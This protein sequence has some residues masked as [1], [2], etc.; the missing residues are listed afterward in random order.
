MAVKEQLLS[1]G[2]LEEASDRDVLLD[3]APWWDSVFADFSALHIRE[4][5][6]R[7]ENISTKRKARSDA[8]NAASGRNTPPSPSLVAPKKRE[9]RSRSS[10]TTTA[11]DSV[12]VKGSSSST[13]HPVDFA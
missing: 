2:S 3:K 6:Q 7:K 8:K 13:N 10:L 12:D 11:D 4:T 5:L 9:P 1:I